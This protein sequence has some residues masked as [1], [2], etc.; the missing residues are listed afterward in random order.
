MLTPTLHI[1]KPK[2]A[3]VEKVKCTCC[4]RQVAN[5]WVKRTMSFIRAI[6]PF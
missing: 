6:T 5:T 3:E 2:I 1:D 4:V